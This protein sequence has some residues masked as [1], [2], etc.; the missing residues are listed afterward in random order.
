MTVLELELYK[1]IKRKLVTIGQDGTAA[2]DDFASQSGRRFE[3]E[4]V[5]GAQQVW[6]GIG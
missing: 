1:Q 4:T 3:I 2:C 6:N 5:A